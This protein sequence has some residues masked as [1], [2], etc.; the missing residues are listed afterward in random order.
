MEKN[1]YDLLNEAEIDLD[2]YDQ[3]YFTD[4]EKRKIKN[5]FKKSIKKNRFVYRKYIVASI[6]LLMIGLFTTN[7]GNHVLAYANTITYDIASFLGIERNLD[8]YKTVVDQSI[9]KNGITIQLNEVILDNDQLVVSTTSKSDEKLEE[10]FISP[11]GSVYV[12]GENISFGGGGGAK[13][14]DAYTVEEVTIYTLDE[15]LD[16]ELNIKLLFSD[17]LINGKTKKGPWVFEF[18]TNGDELALNTD[19]ISLNHTFELEN[20]QKITLEKYTSNNLGPKIY[21]SKSPKGTDYD[22]VLRGYDD[23]GNDI[24]FYLS[25]GTVNTGLFKLSTINGNLNENAKKLS[26]TPYAVK[27]PEQSGRLSNDFKKVGEEFT[28]N[29]LK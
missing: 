8:E 24:E 18:K 3:E 29:L 16:G 13:K 4:I 23:L 6:A 22:M 17:V 19:K 10:G 5:S 21:C 11:I 26:L 7:I 15:V 27:F 1:M 14:I 12:N 28:I 20:G 2:E 25:R 9:S